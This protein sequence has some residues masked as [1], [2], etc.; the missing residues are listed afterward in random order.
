M[1]TPTNPKASAEPRK[2][3]PWRLIAAAA[4]VVLIAGLVFWILYVRAAEDSTAQRATFVVQRGPLTISV[5]ESG[6]I[7][8]RE[9]IIIKN[10]VEGRTSIIRLIPEGTR[11]KTG[12]LLVELDASELVDA[13]IDQD[14]LVQNTEAAYINARENLAVVANQ[15]ESDIDKAQLILEFAEQDVQQYKDGIYPNELAAAQNKITLAQEELTRAQETSKWSETLYQEK[16]ISQTEFLADQLAEKRKSLD[17]E[18]A[19]NDLSL[20]QDFTFHRNIAQLESDLRQATMALER[21]RRKATA[22]VVQAKAELTARLAEFNRQKDKL[23]KIETQIAKTKI[24][25]PADGLVIYATSARARG[26]RDSR[27]PLDEGQEVYERQELIYLPF[28]SSSIA[29]VQVHESSLEK[30]RLG[31][32]TIVTVD[33]LPGRTFLG[34]IHQIAP[35]PDAQS[36]WMNPDLKVY[37][38]EIYLEGND[39]ALRTGMSCKA[40]IIVEQYPDAVYIP[41]QAVLRVKGEPTV[42]VVNG[43]SI[44]PRT[45]ELGLDNNRMIRIVSGLEQ[46]QIVLLTPPLELAGI[47][48][49]DKAYHASEPSDQ[50]NGTMQEQIRSRLDQVND[51][52]DVPP[53]RPA[54]EFPFGPAGRGQ[55][56]GE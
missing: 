7:K 41:L 50:E 33:A 48:P 35:L 34:S 47:D 13:K 9:Q 5:P 22:D 19:K 18:L 54:D 56:P 38:T 53:D 15:A 23:E 11:V 21:T 51:R 52:Q 16:Y 20:L 44:E 3:K 45:V 12:D 27:E 8:A 37:L 32:P 1:T 2:G 40:E 4:A 6:T 36:M 42:F 46:G 29:Q 43:D 28:A 39:P 31:L 55:R 26:W 17:L 10:E 49:R 24:L 25:A 14:I 30:V